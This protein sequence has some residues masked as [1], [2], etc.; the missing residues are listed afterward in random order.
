MESIPAIA[1]V[2]TWPQ[3]VFGI[4]VVLAVLVVPQVISL[5]Q[6]RSIQHE[7]K[8]NSGS[9][10]RDAINRIEKTLTEHVASENARV[11]DVESRLNKLEEPS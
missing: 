2:L 1:E 10:M 7:L 11:E 9:S 4:V 6:N 5:I 8:P 3:A